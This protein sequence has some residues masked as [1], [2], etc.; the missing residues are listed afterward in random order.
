[1]K[2]RHSIGALHS[3]IRSWSFRFVLCALLSSLAVPTCVAQSKAVYLAPP[4]KPVTMQDVIRLT[5]AGVSD[6]VIIEELKSHKERFLLSA[7]QIIQLKQAKVSD[8]VIATMINPDGSGAQPARAVAAPRPVTPA[9]PPA[10]PA[11]VPAAQLSEGM[12]TQLGIYVK[13]KD[14]W[15]ALSPEVVTWKSGSLAKTVATGGIV[16]G[17]VNGYVDA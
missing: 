8:R 7:D 13:V 11:A 12:P 14:D 2:L 5:K 16:K 9:K 17:D 3:S 10:N 4:S 6:D 15:I 1:M